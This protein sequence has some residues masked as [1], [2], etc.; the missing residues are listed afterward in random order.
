M[1]YRAQH[2]ISKPPFSLLLSQVLHECQSDQ[3]ISSH[4]D[5]CVDRGSCNIKIEAVYSLNNVQTW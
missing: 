3:Y 5:A 2:T 1:N 4:A